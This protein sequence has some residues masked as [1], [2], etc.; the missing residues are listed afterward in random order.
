VLAPNV[1]NKFE[2]YSITKQLTT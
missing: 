1:F 2:K